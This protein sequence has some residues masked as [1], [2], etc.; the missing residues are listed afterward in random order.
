MSRSTS[1]VVRV[2]TCALL[3]HG[4]VHAAEGPQT[5]ERVRARTLYGQGEKLFKSGDVEGAERAFE[6]AYRTMPNAVVLLKIADCKQKLNDYPGAVEILEKYLVERRDPPDRAAVEDRIAEMR[7]KPGT[8]SLRS[9]PSGASIWVDGQ[10]SALVTPSDV[11]LPPGEHKLALK[12]PPYSPTEQTIIV[13]FGSKK[14]LE[15]TLSQPPPAAPPSPVAPPNSTL[16]PEDTGTGPWHPNAGFWVAVGATAA[17]AAVTTV[18]G[19]V[20]LNK[21]SDYEKHP[22]KQIADD[23]ERAAIISDIGLGVTVAGAVTA[24]VLYFT[25]GRRKHS[26]QGFSVGPMI[27]K[28]GGGLIGNARF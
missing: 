22:T 18:F 16:Q 26:E 20:A 28:G 13:E 12:L 23:G 21:H 11:E 3:M 19:V 1:R 2:V 27:G 5:P 24:T 10:D 8:L 14:E 15:L 17:G 6:D 9:A 7:R 4:A 25:T